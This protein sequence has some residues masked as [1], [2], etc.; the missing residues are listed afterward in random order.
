MAT[1]ETI[2]QNEVGK[3]ISFATGL[4][5][6]QLEGVTTVKIMVKKPGATT[7]VLW[8][9]QLSG[10]SVIY[11]TVEGDFDKLGVYYMRSYFEWGAGK[12]LKGKPVVVLVEE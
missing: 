10:T 7:W 1:T 8:D 2:Y 3:D 4:T 11:T 12:K 5:T 9:A 6:T